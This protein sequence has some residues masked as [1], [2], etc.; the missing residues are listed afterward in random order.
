[1]SGKHPRLPEWLRAKTVRRADTHVLRTSLR[2]HGLHTV[3]EEARCPNAGECFGDGTAAFLILG[4]ACTRGCAFCAVTRNAPAPVDPDEPAA[5]AAQAAAL[6]LRHVVITSVTRAALPDGGAAQFAASIRRVR[7]ALPRATVEVLV[8]DFAGSG[9]ALDAVLGA[10]PDVLNHNVETVRER[11]AAVR[12]GAVYER[13][14]EL[15]HRAARY[16]PHAV[17][18]LRRRGGIKGVVVIKS[19]LMVGLGETTEQL[20]A[21]FRDLREAGVRALT[22]GQYLRPRRANIAVARYY[23]PAEFEVLAAGAR[24]LGFDAVFAGPLVRSSY[25]AGE[26]F[27]TLSRKT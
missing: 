16:K 6:G 25:H 11:Y 13:S 19:G 18:P 22:I 20:M 5:V 12:P 24:T 2:A 10:A 17:P 15:L 4:G 3:C 14:I 7:E 26:T 23:T 1:M 8:P 21:C 9:E 27:A